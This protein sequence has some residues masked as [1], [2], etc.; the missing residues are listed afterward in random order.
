MHARHNL[1]HEFL[2]MSC[3]QKAIRRGQEEDA[4]YWALQLIYH[5]NL[6]GS[7]G[8]TMLW[9]RL[10][11]IASEDIGPANSE[12]SIL[13]HSLAE[14]DI[15]INKGKKDV[16]DNK[17]GRGS[18][19]TDIFV[20]HAILYLCRSLKNREVDDFICHMNGKIKFDNYKAEIPDYAYDKHTMEGRRDGRGFKHFYDGEKDDHSDAPT[21]LENVKGDSK[22][23]ESARNYGLKEDEEE[24]KRNKNQ[25]TLPF[26]RQK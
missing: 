8:R 20:S 19:P 18:R 21:H 22:Y 17:Q 13:I 10:R 9:N 5:H 24:A 11:V 7:G 1:N 12:A 23:Y 15:A 4:L 26:A 2:W 3:L 6:T 14:N 25:I 16:T